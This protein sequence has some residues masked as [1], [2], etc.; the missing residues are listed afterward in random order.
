MWKATRVVSERLVELLDPRPGETIL[1]LAAGPGD[2]GFLAAPRLE[3]GGVLLSTDAAAEMVEAARRNAAA[4]GV[5]NVEF[6]VLDAAAVDLADDAVD[7]I[8]CRWGL[9][10]VPRVAAAFGEVA[11]VLRP[12]GRVAVAVWAE[13][14]RN[15]WMTAHGRAALELGLIERPPADA[16]GPFRLSAPG[17][18]EELFTG[19]G[20]IVEAV[21]DVELTW[22]AES[23][24]EWWET[25]RDLSRMINDLLESITPE[26]AAAL[27][28]AA[29]RRLAGYVAADGSLA[30]PS[31]TRV[32]LAT[33]PAAV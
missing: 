30:V 31:V 8:L 4:L 25:T 26:Q 7:G 3:P 16:P 32:A 13:P 19:A 2:T 9:M 18:L 33:K 23:L 12:G 10:L 15:D 24:E 1:D 28:A 20:L 11:R 21:E 5:A 27:R 29:E 14:D 17:A 22:R 6:R